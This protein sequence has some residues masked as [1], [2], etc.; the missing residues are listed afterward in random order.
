MKL[1]L[2]RGL[3]PALI[4]LFACVAT[5]E[6]AKRASKSKDEPI[7]TIDMFAAMKSGDIEVKVVAKDSTT[8]NVLIK[9]KSK[10]PL[11]IKLPE[12]FVG[13]PVAAQ[14]GGMGMG[15]M[16]G[17]GMGGMGMGGMGGMGGGGFGGM[18]GFGG[19]GFFK[20]EPEKV[21]KLKM[22]IMC[23]DHGKRDPTPR[24]AYELRP[25][26]DEIS[27]PKVAELIKMLG[28]GEIDQR[29]AQAAVWHLK[30]GMSWQ[31]LAAKIGAKHLNGTTE[32]YFTRAELQ[33]GMQYASEA[34][35]RGSKNA[36]EA[37]GKQDSLSTASA[38]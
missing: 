26:D 30:N 9:N 5:V 37:P 8:G 24:I 20:V 33:R 36:K 6:A 38:N 16:G 1:S 22:N 21:G 17:M 14:F 27:D 34:T 19:G 23:L 13:V 11:A 28:R 29:G 4:I 35:I 7:D 18:G 32:P 25:V 12:A 2:V 3:V 15:G 10:K 31:E